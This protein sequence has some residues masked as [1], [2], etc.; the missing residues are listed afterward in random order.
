M[1]NIKSLIFLLL[2]TILTVNAQ[3]IEK[4]VSD[5]ASSTCDCIEKIEYID[6]KADFEVKVKSCAA[7]SAKDST[8]VFRQTTFHEYDKLLQSKLFE[9]CNAIEIKLAKLRK[10]YLTTNMDSLYSAEKQYKDIEENL[11]GAYNLSFGSRSPEGSPTLF[12]YHQNKYVITS[13]GEIQMGTWRVVKEKYL[14][15]NPNKTKYPFNVYG[16]YNP[17]IGDTTKTSF[18]GDRFSYRTLITYN[19]TSKNPINLT[20]IFN[21]D[22]NCFDFPYVHKTTSVPKQISLALNQSY[23]ESADQKITLYNFKNTTNF[24]DFIV[25]E[26]TRAENKMPIR[27]LIDGNK[28]VFRESQVTEKSSLPKVGS[29]DDTFLKE[30]STINNTPETIYYN[31]G[32]KQFKS[33]EINSKNYSYNK[34]LNNF[35]YRE[36][37]PPS[38]EKNVSA[39]DNFLQVNKYIMLQDVTQQQKEFKIDKK[40]IIYTVCD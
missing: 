9:D 19:E 32:Y 13:F 16:R 40:S 3:S 36:K 21:K 33:E 37:V 27:V 14:H 38:Y 20:P 22:A 8:K 28:L 6:S 2:T 4:I 35:I 7:L 34:K 23:E 39:Y 24:N 26:H 5:K 31:F 25:F 11:I 18:L 17:S 1:K 30:M 29:E 10:N 15:L 12:L